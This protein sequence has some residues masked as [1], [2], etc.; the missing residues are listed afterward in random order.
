MTQ[1]AK[2][3]FLWKT[4]NRIYGFVIVFLALTIV[5]LFC[6]KQYFQ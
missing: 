6:F 4:W 5:L 1:P 3:Q 2:K